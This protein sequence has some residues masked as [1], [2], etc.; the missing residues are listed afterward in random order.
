MRRV[1]AMPYRLYHARKLG[2]EVCFDDSSG[3][4]RIHWPDI[5][6]SSPANLT[7]CKDAALAWAEQQTMTEKRN[8]GVK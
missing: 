7:R 4:Y 2:V 5:G 8:I 3:L 6:I 1:T